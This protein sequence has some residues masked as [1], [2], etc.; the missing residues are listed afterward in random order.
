M[1]PTPAVCLTQNF[2][3]HR[4][5]PSLRLSSSSNRKHFTS[6]GFRPGRRGQRKSRRGVCVTENAWWIELNMLN[7]WTD[8]VLFLRVLQNT[9]GAV[10]PARLS[11]N[12]AVLPSPKAASEV[13]KGSSPPKPGLSTPPVPTLGRGYT[14]G[15]DILL[16]I[17]PPPC[18][19][20][21]SAAKVCVP[22][23]TLNKIMQA[24]WG[25][26]QRH[27]YFWLFLHYGFIFHTIK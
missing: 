3:D 24:A 20:S 21:I 7:C 4:F 14:E 11:M 5:S 18:S 22:V 25:E 16:D 12:S 13:P 2:P 23:I 8:F 15:E 10:I 26:N 1:A 6:K 17:S 19:K 27:H 9:G